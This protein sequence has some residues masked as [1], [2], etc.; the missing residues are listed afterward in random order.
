[1]GSGNTNRKALGNRFPSGYYWEFKFPSRIRLGKQSDYF[2]QW[3]PLGIRSPNRK[4]LGNLSSQWESIGN[5]FSQC[6]PLG[7]QFPSRK[8][9]GKQSKQPPPLF[10]MESHW[11]SGMHRKTF[12]RRNH[13]EPDSQCKS[14]GKAELCEKSLLPGPLNSFDLNALTQSVGGFSSK[15]LQNQVQIHIQGLQRARRGQPKP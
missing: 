8:A 3:I 15:H 10:P 9:L 12:P 6:A 2:S 7:N 11:E 4:P 1:M 14:I 13:W 5:L